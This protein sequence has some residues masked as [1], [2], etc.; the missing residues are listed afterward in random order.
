MGAKQSK[1]KLS[2][3][4]HQASEAG[5]VDAVR[6]RGRSGADVNTRDSYDNAPINSAAFYGKMEV[7]QV[8]VKEFSC[9]PHTKGFNGRT[10]LHQACACGHVDVARKLVTEYGADLN[11][12][13]NDDNTPLNLAARLSG[14]MELINMLVKEYGCSPHTKGF[15]GRTLL[16]NA[17]NGGHVDVARKLVTEYGAD[18]NARDNDDNTPLNL[19]ARFSSKMELIHMLVKEC[20]CSPHTKGFKDRTSLHSACVSGHVDVARKLVT[21]YGADVNA[22]DNDGD[23]PLTLAAGLEKLKWFVC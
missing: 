19:A 18:V 21:E 12:R 6:K 7:I 16:H 11:A 9:S 20:G 17:C 4:L 23:T 14:K 5:D 15:N 2:E 8:L 13:D 1:E 3:S 22:R 10:P